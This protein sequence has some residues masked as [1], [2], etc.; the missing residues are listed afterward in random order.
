MLFS[1]SI[2]IQIKKGFKRNPLSLSGRF[3]SISFVFSCSYA[4]MY[5]SLTIKLHAYK[6]TFIMGRMKQYAP[7]AT[8]LFPR[9]ISIN[10]HLL[11]SH[12]LVT[13]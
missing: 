1:L 8:V 7:M 9:G 11:R 4:Y 12:S 13:I 2:T 6:H 3:A 10:P 5:L